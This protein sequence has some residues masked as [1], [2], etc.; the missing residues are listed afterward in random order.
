MSPATKIFN[1]I[2]GEVRSAYGH[3]DFRGKSILFVGMDKIGQE[4]LVRLCIEDVNLYFMDHSIQNYHAAYAICGSINPYTGV[5]I[6]ITLN[7]HEGTLTVNGKV[8]A[9]D[10]IGKT[11]YPQGIHDFYF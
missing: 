4:I 6:D 1:Y 9:L 8:Q 7:F 3:E 5:P 2:R 11:P 10:G